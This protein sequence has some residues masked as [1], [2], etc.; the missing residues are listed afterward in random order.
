LSESSNPNLNFPKYSLQT[1]TIPTPHKKFSPKNPKDEEDK[2]H[3]IAVTVP[4]QRVELFSRI[5]TLPKILEL[6]N[7]S[8]QTG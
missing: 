8:I 6:E 7:F 1:P 3:L 2:N 4:T 5:I